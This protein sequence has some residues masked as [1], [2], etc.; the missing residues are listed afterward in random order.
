MLDRIGRV[1]PVDFRRLENDFGS[2]FHRAQCGGGVSGELRVARS[3]GKYDHAPFF[4]VANCTS[5]DE[6]FGHGAH[7]DGS[8]H[9]RG[10]AAFRV[11]PAGQGR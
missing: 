9:A 3:G 4:E 10:N 7:L 11:R 5:S 2:D 8:Q 1:N 6:W